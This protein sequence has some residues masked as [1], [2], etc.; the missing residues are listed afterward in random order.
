MIEVLK[1]P[2]RLARRLFGSPPVDSQQDQKQTLRELV[3]QITSRHDVTLRYLDIGASGGSCDLWEWMIRQQI[4]DAVLID[5]AEWGDDSIHGLPNVTAIKAAVGETETKQQVSITRHPACSSCLPPNSEL[6]A[7]YPVR[8]WFEVVR[9]IDVDA[10]SYSHIA[11]EHNPGQVHFVKMDV[12]GFEGQVLRGMR[13]HLNNAL[14]VEFEC[15]MKPIYEGQE[16]FFDLYNLMVGKGF[17][18]RDLRP[19]GPFEGEALEFNS[20]WCREPKTDA[21]RLMIKVWET[22][23]NIWPGIYFKDVDAHQRRKYKFNSPDQND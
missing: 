4:I 10:R 20:Y 14:C 15:Q 2:I 19:Q 5:M 1:K 13:E 3:S 16:T 9:T 22:A 17:Q 23:T 18:L 7:G 8:D 12:Q 11:A 21:E 6:L